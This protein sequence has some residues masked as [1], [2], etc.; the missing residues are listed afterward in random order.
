MARTS[1]LVD[2]GPEELLVF[3]Q[4]DVID[5]RGVFMAQP[6][7]EHPVRL[8]V[9]VS[10]DRQSD[11]ELDGQVNNKII[12]VITR[13]AP[14]DSWA[15]IHFRGEAWDLAS[16]PAIVAGSRFSKAVRHVSFILRSRNERVDT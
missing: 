8:M 1:V 14:V 12:K 11:A 10:T 2:T 9:T 6:D 7:M 13:S 15:R 3:P 5:A 4:V 16:P